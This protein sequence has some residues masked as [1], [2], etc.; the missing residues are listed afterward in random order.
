MLA[1]CWIVLKIAP[2]STRPL[3]RRFIRVWTGALFCF[4]GGVHRGA[5]FYNPRSPQ[6][7]DPVIFLCLHFFG[8][9]M[10]MAPDH[11]FKRYAPAGMLATLAG[12]LYLAKQRRLPPFFLRL[13]PLQLLAAYGLLILATKDSLKDQ[14]R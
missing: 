5:S 6:L 1:V 8:L 12:E 10:I 3:I 13:R 4:F 2:V 11:V 14:T 7:S 9:S